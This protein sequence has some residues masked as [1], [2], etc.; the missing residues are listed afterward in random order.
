MGSSWSSQKMSVKEKGSIPTAEIVKDKDTDSADKVLL[1]AAEAKLMQE[2]R[3]KE[4]VRDF[5][6]FLKDAIERAI[7]NG[8]NKTRKLFSNATIQ[9]YSLD[10][11]Y[12]REAIM[13]SLKDLGYGIEWALR[14]KPVPLLS[15]LDRKEYDEKW[16]RA[17]CFYEIAILIRW[18]DIS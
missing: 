8:W 5:L 3:V 6:G 7:G 10:C 18:N 12:V 11:S 13:K 15:S 16:V 17:G 9:K 4:I 2:K 14:P 1:S